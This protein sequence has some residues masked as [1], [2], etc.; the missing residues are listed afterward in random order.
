MSEWCRSVVSAQH[1]QGRLLFGPCK[2]SLAGES[3]G[4]LCRDIFKG[5]YIRNCFG[6]N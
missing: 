3:V 4:T 2:V 1:I 5:S 6:S